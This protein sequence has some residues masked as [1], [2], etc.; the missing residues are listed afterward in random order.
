MTYVL[1]NVLQYP[2]FKID[3]RVA[4]EVDVFSW[5]IAHNHLYKFRFKEIDIKQFLKIILEKHLH[6]NLGT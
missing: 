6:K 4:T 3:C 1:N 2:V 5:R